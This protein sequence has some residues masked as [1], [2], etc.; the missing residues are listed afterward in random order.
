MSEMSINSIFQRFFPIL[1]VKKNA[2]F[3]ITFYTDCLSMHFPYPGQI[4]LKKIPTSHFSVMRKKFR[5]GGRL[6]SWSISLYVHL[7]VGLLLVI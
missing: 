2:P 5:S 6:V 4:L 3:I 1:F 7:S